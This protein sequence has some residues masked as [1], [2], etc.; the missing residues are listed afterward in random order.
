MFKHSTDRINSDVFARVFAIFHANIFRAD[1]H[2]NGFKGSENIQ[3]IIQLRL[4][5]CIRFISY[6]FM[7]EFVFIP[8]FS[9]GSLLSFWHC[10]VGEPNFPFPSWF[11]TFVL[12]LFYFFFREIAKTETPYQFEQPE[13][14][15]DLYLFYANAIRDKHFC[16]CE[17]GYN[18][19]FYITTYKFL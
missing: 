6:I 11:R 18:R 1:N 13:N 17:L 10:E 16:T 2:I 19:K 4:N 14:C 7:A 8:S 15:V 12:F 5:Q 3:S 9:N